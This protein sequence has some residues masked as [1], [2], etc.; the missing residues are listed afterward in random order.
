MTT[1]GDIR[2]LFAAAGTAPA[3]ADPDGGARRRVVSAFEEDLLA[4]STLTVRM[5]GRAEDLVATALG[6]AE[7]RDSGAAEAAEAGARALYALER[8][9]AERATAVLA[10]R[11]PMAADLR[12]LLAS[13]R[14]ATSLKRIGGLARD[15]AARGAT[16]G[17]GRPHDAS[18]SVLRLGRGALGQLSEALSAHQARDAGRALAVARRDRALDALC[19][20]LMGALVRRMAEEPATVGEGAQWLFVTKNLERI[21]DHAAGIARATHY[22]VA[23]REIDDAPAA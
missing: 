12:M 3:P 23:G 15:V 1:Y 16:L 6:A 18:A 8:K 4:V 13:M 10:L 20:S 5:G 2:R 22:M 17:P 9:L 7:R 21:G 19:E 14:V 11:Q